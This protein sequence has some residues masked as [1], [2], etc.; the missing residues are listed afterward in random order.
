MTARRMK[1][2]SQA[3][4]GSVDAIMAGWYPRSMLM[5]GKSISRLLVGEVRRDSE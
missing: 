1:P 3:P 4:G 2:C 5:I